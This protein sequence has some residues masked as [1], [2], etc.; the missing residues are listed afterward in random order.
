MAEWFRQ[1]TRNPMGFS[2]VGSNAAHDVSVIYMSNTIL[3]VRVCVCDHFCKSGLPLLYLQ[4]GH[5]AFTSLYVYTLTHTHTHTHIHVK[6][7]SL[8]NPNVAQ[9]SITVYAHRLHP[10]IEPSFLY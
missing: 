4:Y 1:W 8:K 5:V 7:D 2:C 9:Q 10:Q 6:W 3:S